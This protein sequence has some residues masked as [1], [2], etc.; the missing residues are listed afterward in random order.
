MLEGTSLPLL[1]H[2]IACT[3]WSLCEKEASWLP[4]LV[5]L[6]PEKWRLGKCLDNSPFLTSAPKLP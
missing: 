4:S 5:Y 3:Y 1:A 2:P 6:L